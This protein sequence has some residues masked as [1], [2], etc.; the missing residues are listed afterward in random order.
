MQGK[1]V[2]DLALG[3]SAEMRHEHDRCA[4]VE[5]SF[6]GG[7]RGADACVAGNFAV[8]DRLFRKRY[9]W[10][11]V[12]LPELERRHGTEL[13]ERIYFHIAAFE[14]IPMASLRPRQLD[15]GAWARFATAELERLWRQV[16]RG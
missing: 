2:F 12:D 11:G 15:F 4:S 5:S 13:L 7:K 6:D 14:A 8:D 10:Q 16:L 3:R 1:F 9:R